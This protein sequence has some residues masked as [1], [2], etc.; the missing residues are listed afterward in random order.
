MR[1]PSKREKV[2][3]CCPS[4]VFLQVVLET[5]LGLQWNG[6][7]SKTFPFGLVGRMMMKGHGVSLVEL[8]V[9]N[10]DHLF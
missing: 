10:G 4:H 8:N 6:N 5:L 7:L 3:C 9:L 2:V 1:S